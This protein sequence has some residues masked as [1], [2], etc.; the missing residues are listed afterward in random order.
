[1]ARKRLS[2]VFISFFLVGLTVQ[3]TA[4]EVDMQLVLA[5]DVSSSVN[6]DEYNLQMRGFAA[7]FRDDLVI[8]AITA[9]PRGRISIAATHWAGL[10]EQQTILDWQVIASGDDARAYRQD[11]SLIFRETASF[12]SAVPRRSR[13]TA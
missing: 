4:E 11:G 9:G 6:Y 10:R 1:M 5:I 12:P 2:A 3:A 13:A 8:E 7:A